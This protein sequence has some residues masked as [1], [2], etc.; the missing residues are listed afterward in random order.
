M[1]LLTK[2]PVTPAKMK[3]NEEMIM[4]VVLKSFHMEPRPIPIPHGTQTHSHHT[5]SPDPFP[6]HMEPRPIL[7]P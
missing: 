2:T 7:P 3:Q 5:W 6:S 4:L 1:Y